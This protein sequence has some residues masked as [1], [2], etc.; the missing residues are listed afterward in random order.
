MFAIRDTESSDFYEGFIRQWPALPRV[1]I[2]LSVSLVST[3][4]VSPEDRYSV[5]KVRSVEGAVSV[6][7][8]Q[9]CSKSKGMGVF[10]QAS[11]E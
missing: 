5:T 10:C 11:T 4:R 8:P 1:V 9:C 2:F 7:V 6:S 3:A